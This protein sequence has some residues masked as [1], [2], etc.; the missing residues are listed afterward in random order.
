M[1][2]ISMYGLTCEVSEKKKCSLIK[3]LFLFKVGFDYISF[4]IEMYLNSRHSK[5]KSF[6]YLWSHQFQ[7]C[8][9]ITIHWHFLMF[10][11]LIH[12]PWSCNENFQFCSLILTLKR[13]LKKEKKSL[14]GWK[15]TSKLWSWSF[16]LI[17]PLTR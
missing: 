11:T 16:V 3:I 4:L 6:V 10:L 7:H 1:G 15:T 17:L 5:K 8:W 13:W 2:S 9:F 12:A 14:K